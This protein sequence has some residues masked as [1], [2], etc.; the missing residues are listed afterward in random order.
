VKLLNSIN[1]IILLIILTAGVGASLQAKEIYGEFT[2][3]RKNSSEHKASEKNSKS[4]AQYYG[5]LSFGSI[6]NIP[7]G[8]V[9]D[10]FPYGLSASLAY[11]QALY[12]KRN[13]SPW[14]P[15]LRF[16]AG[17]SA[18]NKDENRILWYDLSGGPSWSI[19][20]GKSRYGHAAFALMGGGSYV[21]AKGAQEDKSGFTP[22]ATALLGYEY[23]IGDLFLFLHGRYSYLY[24]ENVFM[25]SAGASFGAGYNL[26]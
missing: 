20:L 10:I 4:N 18:Y 11:E 25:H 14:I 19:P 7:F 9:K 26:W 24:D 12:L 1:S 3:K 15:S 8:E 16:E 5:R 23:Y 22:S 17:F 2:E 13:R 21:Q 6:F